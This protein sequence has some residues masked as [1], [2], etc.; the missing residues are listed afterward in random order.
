MDAFISF[1]L[2]IGHTWQNSLEYMRIVEILNEAP[3]F[4]WRN[5]SLWEKDAIIN[6][7]SEFGKAELKQKLEEQ[8]KY[9]DLVLICA[10][11][12]ISHPYWIEQ[13][14]AIAAKFKKP[15]VVVKPYA[16]ERTPVLLALNAK[17]LVD[18]Q[19]SS[20]VAAIKKHGGK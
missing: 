15:L 18:W 20:I 10:D 8:I 14:V 2:F 5:Y 7:D 19:S 17:E 9:V 1:D 12:Y 4:Y 11:Q 13:E 6:T 3:H 16:N